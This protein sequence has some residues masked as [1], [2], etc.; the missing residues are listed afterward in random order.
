MG[1]GFIQG[2]SP[3]IAAYTHRGKNA[4]TSAKITVDRCHHRSKRWLPYDDCSPQYFQDASCS[5]IQA[6]WYLNQNLPVNADLPR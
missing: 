3:I 5:V 6:E 2:K 1:C 4:S